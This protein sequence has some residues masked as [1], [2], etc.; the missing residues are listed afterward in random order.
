MKLHYLWLL[1][2]LAA[3]PL[4]AQVIS[5]EAVF[6]PASTYQGPGDVFSTSPYAWYSCARAFNAAYAAAQGNACRVVK[7]S[8]GSGGCDLKVSTNGFVSSPAVQCPT[9]CAS[10]CSVTTAYDQTGNGRDAI[11]ATLSNMPPLAMTST[12]TGTLPAIDCGAGA[13]LL[14][15][16]PTVTQAQPLAFSAVFFQTSTGSPAGMFGSSSINLYLGGGGTNI[17]QVSGGTVL[18]ATAANSNWHAVNALANGNGSS[19]A[20]NVNG[21]DTTGA[22]GTTGF[23]ATGIRICRAASASQWNRFLAEAGIWAAATTA[24]DRG[25]LNTNQHGANGYNF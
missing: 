15:S 16:G 4:Y 25:N 21:S 18:S 13:V 8:D 20:I 22:A 10:A 9:E 11:Q 2:L 12:P 19:S 14:L 1:A 24:T 23:S 17:T 7:T 6:K 3:P 5:D